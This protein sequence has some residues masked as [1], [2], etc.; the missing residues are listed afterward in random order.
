MRRST[1]ITAAIGALT[2]AIGTEAQALDCTAL[3]HVPRTFKLTRAQSVDGAPRPSSDLHIERNGSSTMVSSTL[4]N[5]TVMR[6]AMEGALPL[7]GDIDSHDKPLRHVYEYSDAQG[8]RGSLVEGA[9]S[10]WNEHYTV[11]GTA[12]LADE[13]RQTIGAHG[14]TM[15]SGCPIATV[16]IHREMVSTGPEGSKITLD[17]LFA[18]ELGYW[19][20]STTKVE[21]AASTAARESIM[22]ATA[23]EIEK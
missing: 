21:S 13:V 23:L 22:K 16:A 12:Y 18:P 2:I 15:L 7:W 11:N 20:A 1:L 8:A 19:I 6:T 10:S 4:S 14:T 5:G 9:M 17:L 3:S